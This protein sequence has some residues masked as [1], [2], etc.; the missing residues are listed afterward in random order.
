MRWSAASSTN[1][2]DGYR[3]A[4]DVV[5]DGVSV[6]WWPAALPES[7]TLWEQGGIRQLSVALLSAR[8][9]VSE[10]GERAPHAIR[11]HI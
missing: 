7:L 3:V 11:L 2:N 8:F 6:Q 10:G 5:R 1:P 4:V 9:T